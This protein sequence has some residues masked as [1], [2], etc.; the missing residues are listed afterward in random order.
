MPFQMIWDDFCSW[1]LEMV[2]PNYGE[3][4]DRTTLSAVKKFFEDN[5]RLLHPFMPFITEEIWHF[6]DKRDTDEALVVSEWPKSQPTDQHCIDDFEIVK[7]IVSGIRNFRKE[8]NIGFKEPL[9]LISKTKI[10]YS[11]VLKK[12]AQ[13]ESID[14]TS[15]GYNHN[16]GS[17]RVG[18]SEFFIPLNQGFDHERERNKLAQELEYAKGF[19]KSVE[20]KLSDERF[21]SNAPD[22][23]IE[24]ERKK[25]TDAKEKIILLE[26]SLSQL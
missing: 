24:V 11:E 25:A 10:P 20:K 17:F 21:L 15:K 12:L 3:P 5:L 16:F 13:L 1:F 4:I 14:N 26:K 22:K 2:K 9:I 18:Q 7:K 19:L 6:I 23:V 8:K